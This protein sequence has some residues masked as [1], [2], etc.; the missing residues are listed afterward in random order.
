MEEQELLSKV[1]V[2]TKVK[3]YR[4]KKNYMILAVGRHS[5]TLELMVVYQALY[6]CEKFGPNPIFIRPL[7]MF[8]E[9]VEENGQTMPRFIEI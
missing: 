6:D 7:E 4:N 3:H 5:E 1:K 2:G 9:T 8:L